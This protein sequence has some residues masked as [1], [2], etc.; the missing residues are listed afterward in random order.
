MAKL[1]DLGAQTASSPAEVGE[2]SD[3][4]VSMLPNNQH[5]MDV[6]TGENGVLK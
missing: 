1:G 4:I 6:Y 2:K 5:V 3:T